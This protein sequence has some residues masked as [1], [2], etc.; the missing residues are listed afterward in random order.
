MQEDL[1]IQQPITIEDLDDLSR[2]SIQAQF[3]GSGK[4][5]KYL[6]D[7][8]SLKIERNSDKQVMRFTY[9]EGD[10]CI[11]I[12]D[13]LMRSME[14][15]QIASSIAMMMGHAFLRHRT[16]IKNFKNTP[17]YDPEL[18]DEYNNIL[19]YWS[20]LFIEKMLGIKIVVTNGIS[21]G[22]HL[23]HSLIGADTSSSIGFRDP[24][25]DDHDWIWE[26]E[27]ELNMESSA[28][29][30]DEDELNMESSPNG[31]D[32]DGGQSSNGEEGDDTGKGNDGAA[33]SLSDLMEDLE[34]SM[35]PD[36]FE[37]KGMK[38]SDIKEASKAI[39]MDKEAG[40]QAG[41]VIIE[42]LKTL[43]KKK[44]KWEKVV[45]FTVR[46]EEE[47]I[48]FDAWDK[49][50]RRL[51]IMSKD[52]MMPGKRYDMKKTKIPI[53]LFMDTSGS[54]VSY[55]ERFWKAAESIDPKKFDI[56]LFC[57]DTSVYETTLK[58]RKLY[59]FGGTNFS[60]IE[61][62]IQKVM[63]ADGISYPKAV[64]VIT[65]GWGPSPTPQKPERW[66]WFMTE[67][68][69]TSYVPSQ[70]KIYKLSDYE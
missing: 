44:P 4:L 38:D 14:Y 2:V 28:N 1:E 17:A 67:H 31:G 43:I 11:V 37:Q 70:S 62:E 58:S 21:M 29:G 24:P 55:A 40:T 56:R 9:I 30:E 26:D 12:P 27:D 16:R 22:T 7:S 23:E 45:K 6:Y 42:V 50:D 66:H 13:N 47:D 52:M 25:C 53:F 39:S 33:P 35:M 65:D 60:P 19:D 46:Q 69:T 64:F 20:A 54:C 32:D 34:K 63:K 8:V 5:Y 36:F 57:F 15:V 68:F 10:L 48:E 41:N 51:S 18:R 61:R 59:G 3:F 49:D